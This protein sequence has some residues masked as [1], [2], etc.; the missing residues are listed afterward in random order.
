[1]ENHTRAVVDETSRLVQVLAPEFTAA[2]VAAARWHDLGKAH[3]AFQ[4]MLRG[5][6]PARAAQLWAKSANPGGRCERRF[7]RHELAS[8][9]AWLQTAPPEAPER[10]L[11]AYL[12]AAHHGKVRLSIR[13]L[14]GEEPP[15]DRPDARLA[16]GI[17]DGDPLGPVDLEGVALPAITLDL[18]LMEMGWDREREPQRGPSWL[19]RMIALRDRFGPFRLAYLE[20]LLRAADARASARGAGQDQI[21]VSGVCAGM[22]LR[23]QPPGSG[24]SDSLTPA[25]QSLVADLVADGLSIQDKFRP[26]PLYK[27]TGKGHYESGTVEEIRQAKKEKGTPP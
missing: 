3:Q 16:R 23:E 10:D 27:Q 17:L 18:S 6:D 25:E 4:K 14:P 9:L 8:A 13:S 2:F 24:A 1:L 19:A 26:E 15:P 20:T 22:E 21:A 7:F 12:I 5:N 11:V